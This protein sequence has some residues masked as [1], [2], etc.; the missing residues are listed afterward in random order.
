MEWHREGTTEVQTASCLRFF[1]LTQIP[2][3]PARVCTRAYALR[4]R[5]LSRG[6]VCHSIET[7]LSA[8]RIYD[9]ITFQ[10]VR[11]F[12]AESDYPK[13]FVLLL[14]HPYSNVVPRKGHE[15]PEGE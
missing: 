7:T 3:L 12:S 15:S 4:S 6:H 8:R 9:V 2:Y 11:G 14:S 5:R 1:I 13:I 10:D